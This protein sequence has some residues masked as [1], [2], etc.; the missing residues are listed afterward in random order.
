MAE[1][2][3]EYVEPQ[4]LPTL[5]QS[6]EAAQQEL[7]A[8]LAQ[9][10][11]TNLAILLKDKELHRLR[12]RLQDLEDQINQ[13][14]ASYASDNTFP[15]LLHPLV[16]GEFKVIR[17]QLRDCTDKL[18]LVN[19]DKLSKRL[20]E[21]VAASK[22]RGSIQKYFDKEISATQKET[23]EARVKG[24]REDLEREK[25]HT[26]EME[27]RLVRQ[28][29]LADY[30]VGEIDELQNIMSTVL[31]QT[32]IVEAQYSALTGENGRLGA[33]SR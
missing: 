27:R 14:K 5:L 4:D 3:A 10:Q 24:L 18:T 22:D 9:E 31:A 28:R 21:Q 2:E 29:E 33:A 7:A 12:A 11:R 6:L 30:L 15:V 20:S 26:G 13:N 32:T 19:N 16:N 25:A 17:D 23:S 1:S 8:N